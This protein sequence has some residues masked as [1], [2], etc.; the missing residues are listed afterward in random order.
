M[1]NTKEVFDKLA[2]NWINESYNS[3]EQTIATVRLEIIEQ[4]LKGIKSE[5][6]LDVGCGDG[7][8]LSLFEDITQRM[9]IDYSVN[10][11]ALAKKQ[12]PDIN[13][14][15]ADLNDINLENHLLSN[16]QNK[17]QVMTMMGVVHY[18]DIPSKT[19]SILEKII[20]NNGFFIISFR[21][22]LFNLNKES[23]YHDSLNTQ[24][25]IKYLNEELNYLFKHEEKISI[26]YGQIEKNESIL[27]LLTKIKDDKLYE[28]YTD[29]SWNPEKHN[30]WRQF[31][32]LEAVVL[33]EQIGFSVLK[34]IP[35]INIQSNN[36]YKDATSFV[37]LSRKI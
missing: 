1:N 3:G 33:L 30:N 23:K 8:L 5:S 29:S 4:L 9:G 24:K 20:E 14:L 28:G 36:K 16:I 35:L 6:L 7:R 11:V 17:Y 32:P 15:Q 12:N 37:V 10:M 21:N 26:N 19:I 2:V 22:K 13:F 34:I 27:K 25:N 31:T 18:L